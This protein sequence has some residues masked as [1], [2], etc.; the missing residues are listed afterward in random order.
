MGPTFR[1]GKDNSAGDQADE[2]VNLTSW[3]EGRLERV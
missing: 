1:L 3:K 2:T